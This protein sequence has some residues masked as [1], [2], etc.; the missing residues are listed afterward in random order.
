MNTA[1]KLGD[2]IYLPYRVYGVELD[3]DDEISYYCQ[4]LIYDKS[5]MI[6]VS[7]ENLSKVKTYSEPYDPQK[8]SGQ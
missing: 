5:D 8:F 2:V 6:Y 7:E 1:V 3:G 4:S